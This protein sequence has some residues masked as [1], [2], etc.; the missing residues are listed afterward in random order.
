MQDQGHSQHVA[1]HAVDPS[2]RSCSWCTASSLRGANV[3]W[4]F[5]LAGNLAARE[6]IRKSLWI[7]FLPRFMFV[8]WAC[9]LD[10]PKA[11]FSISSFLCLTGQASI[12]FSFSPLTLLTS[13]T[14][15]DALAL[16]DT[17]WIRCHF[18]I[19]V[20]TSSESFLY[21]QSFQANPICN[22]FTTIW[23]YKEEFYYGICARRNEK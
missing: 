12:E 11:I 18:F 16:L 2:I 6:Y 1:Q 13:L 10:T 17:N 23:S 8:I 7:G 15:S 4:S 19:K 5:F 22:Q 21:S 14:S 20:C 3:F 9:S